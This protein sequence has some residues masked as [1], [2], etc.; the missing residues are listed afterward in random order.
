MPSVKCGEDREHD[1]R[2]RPEGRTAMPL[3]DADRDKLEQIERGLARDHP[4]VSHTLRAHGPAR[5][6][7]VTPVLSAAAVFF[8]A[9]VVLSTMTGSALP[10]LLA[11]PPVGLALLLLRW[12]HFARM[13]PEPSLPADEH[14][15]D[16]P[17]GHPAR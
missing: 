14:H 9:L 13:D 10:A 1:D 17:P 8:V 12:P 16:E 5:R 6:E 3:N 4:E 2:T 11:L 15:R 7:V